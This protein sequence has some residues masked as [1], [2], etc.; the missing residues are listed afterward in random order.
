MFSTP[1][2]YNIHFDSNKL[3][4]DTIKNIKETNTKGAITKLTPY[5]KAIILNANEHKQTKPDKVDKSLCFIF[6]PK[7]GNVRTRTAYP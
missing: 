6:S 5:L 7:N 3:T 2:T 4:T 1:R